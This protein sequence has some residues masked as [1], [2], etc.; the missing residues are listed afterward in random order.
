[1]ATATAPK[2]APPP[3]RQAP[4]ARPAAHAA[5]PAAQAIGVNRGR[6]LAAQ[7]VV[8]YGP[9]GIGKSELC[10]NM[11]QIGIDPLFFDLDNET[12]HLDVA[13]ADWP[14]GATIDWTLLRAT[15]QR[16]DLIEPHGAIVIDNVSKAQQLAQEYA[17]A[18]IPHEKGH[19]VSRFEDYGFG[20]GYSHVY[21]LMLLLL[22]DLDAIVRSGKHVVLIAHDCVAPV[23]NPEGED[24]QRYEMR[25]NDQKNGNV[26]SRVKEWC[27]HMLYVGYDVFAKGGKAQGAGTRTIYSAEL[28]TWLAKSRTLSGD[29]IPYP[30]G[31]DELWRRLFQPP[32]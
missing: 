25:L 9:G 26:R 21:E 15:M 3:A 23:P 32:A 12:N 2:P 7:R 6:R 24:Y 17:V 29:P 5:T 19:I 14:E 1:M 4:A 28:P 30:K 10:A 8:L 16:K 11:Q 20:K 27:D 22:G 13:R 18:N 31:S